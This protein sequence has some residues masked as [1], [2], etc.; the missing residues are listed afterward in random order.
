MEEYKL[1][2][3]RDSGE[4]DQNLPQAEKSGDEYVY[5]GYRAFQSWKISFLR[6]CLIKYGVIVVFVASFTAN[7]LLII[8]Y[9]IFLKSFLLRMAISIEPLNI[10]LYC[11][12]IFYYY[13]IKIEYILMEMI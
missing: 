8:L 4:D 5:D 10:S 9:F 11:Q 6:N 1:L 2:M 3:K 7:F 13:L 12:Y